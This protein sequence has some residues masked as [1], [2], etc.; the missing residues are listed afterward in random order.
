VLPEEQRSA[1]EVSDRRRALR[2]DVPFHAKV[3]GVDCAG[4][5]FSIETV[6]DNIGR[7]GLYMRMMSDVEM[8]AQL[9]RFDEAHPDACG[10]LL[11][12]V[13]LTDEELRPKN[14]VVL[15]ANHSQFDYQRLCRLSSLIVDTRN[16]LNCELRNGSGPRI[17]RL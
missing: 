16:A 6:L 9:L 5:H 2:I 1:T 14:C 7:N 3:A 17:I 4:R 15:V 12:S 10:E 8:G 13:T 11:E